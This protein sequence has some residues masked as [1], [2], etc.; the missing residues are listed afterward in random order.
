MRILSD[1][2]VKSASFTKGEEILERER[3]SV[4]QK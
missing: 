1:R 2:V 4:S 3:P